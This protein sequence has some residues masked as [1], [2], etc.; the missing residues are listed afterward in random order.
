MLNSRIWGPTEE[1]KR[2][3]YCTSSFIGWGLRVACEQKCLTANFPNSGTISPC[4][5]GTGQGPEK[6]KK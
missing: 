6:E 5:R 2:R 4:R 1:M 3:Q